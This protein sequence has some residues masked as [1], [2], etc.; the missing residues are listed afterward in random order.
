MRAKLGRHVNGKPMRRLSYGTGRANRSSAGRKNF[1]AASTSSGPRRVEIVTATTSK[2]NKGAT[3]VLQT[4]TIW[5]KTK[6]DPL[7]AHPR[8][9][10]RDASQLNVP[11]DIQASRNDLHASTGDEKKGEI[12]EA[13]SRAVGAGRTHFHR[14]DS[15]IW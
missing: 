7:L 2:V 5:C 3:M 8:K 11:C 14:C 12:E 6:V 4:F 9:E 13:V 15:T 1:G 10:M